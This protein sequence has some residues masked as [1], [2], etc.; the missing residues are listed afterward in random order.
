MSPDARLN[1]GIHEVDPIA[2][3]LFAVDPFEGIV[4]PVVGTEELESRKIPQPSLDSIV[5]PVTT[6]LLGALTIKTPSSSSLTLG[7]EAKANPDGLD[8]LWYSRGSLSAGRSGALVVWP[9]ERLEDDNGS[10]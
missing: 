5:Q 7:T 2:P 10:V 6:V 1:L 4:L 9:L 3:S 8:C